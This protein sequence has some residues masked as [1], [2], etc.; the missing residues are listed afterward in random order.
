[1]IQIL[2]SQVVV[3]NCNEEIDKR[4]RNSVATELL[5]IGGH[6]AW[7]RKRNPRFAYRMPSGTLFFNPPINGLLI[8]FFKD[9]KLREF[10][11]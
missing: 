11:M 3:H 2:Q 1:M 9:Y 10:T 6:S 7:G 4:T 8:D 5:Q